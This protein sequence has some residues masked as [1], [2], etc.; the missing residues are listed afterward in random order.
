MSRDRQTRA[1]AVSAPSWFLGAVCEPIHRNTVQDPLRPAN[2]DLEASFVDI[3]SFRR[4]SKSIDIEIGT[5]LDAGY[6]DGH[7]W[8]GCKRRCH[9]VESLMW[10]RRVSQLKSCGGDDFAPRLHG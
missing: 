6:G 3:R 10:V 7:R 9:V 1:G 5:R 2:S 4:K 8:F